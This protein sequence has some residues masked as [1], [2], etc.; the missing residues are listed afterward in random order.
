M[1]VNR[2]NVSS[3]IFHIAKSIEISAY[4]SVYWKCRPLVVISALNLIINTHDRDF[5]PSKSLLPALNSLPPFSPFE[6]FQFLV[7][8][9]RIFHYDDVIKSL[10]FEL[11]YI[12]LSNCLDNE[13]LSVSISVFKSFVYK[14]YQVLFIFLFDT[15]SQRA[16]IST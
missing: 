14:I 12:R 9:R 5:F 13:S 10:R 6:K 15:A 8:T 16:G 11:V 4:I 1:M 2:L 3:V 7:N